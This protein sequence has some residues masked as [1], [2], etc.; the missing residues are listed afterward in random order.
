MSNNIKSI[1]LYTSGQRVR[2]LPDAEGKFLVPNITSSHKSPPLVRIN[3]SELISHPK[4]KHMDPVLTLDD[5]S[6]VR[7]FQGGDST[8][9]LIRAASLC[10]LHDEKYAKK[11]LEKTIANNS[12]L[13]NG[14][15]DFKM[16]WGMSEDD[17]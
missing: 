17:W 5:G 11:I 2:L 13:S 12:S 14:Y 15:E 9:L 8:G 6:K 16:D 4:L 1:S 10:D 3:A 7:V